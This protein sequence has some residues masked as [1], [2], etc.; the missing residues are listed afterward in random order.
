MGTTLMIVELV[1]IG[2]QVLVWVGLLLWPVL[3]RECSLDRLKE[4][5][6]WVPVLAIAGLAVSYMLGLVFDRSVGSLSW[7]LQKFAKF[8]R[9]K[10]LTHRTLKGNE[11]KCDESGKK[12]QCIWSNEKDIWTNER[13]IMLYRAE[14]YKHLENLGRQRRLLR[15]TCVNTV[16][17]LI[18]LAIRH[19][20][21]LPE[22]VWWLLG[23]LAIGA[24]VTWFRS[25]IDY[26][27]AAK[28]LYETATSNKHRV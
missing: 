7:L 28:E 5:G 8:V 19:P 18:V 24:S 11:T 22:A 15:A 6:D 13:Y 27:R 1:V 16:I 26:A 4:L 25:R 9:A 20:C 23:P 17:A 10:L 12:A 14:A 3:G 21:D 2:F